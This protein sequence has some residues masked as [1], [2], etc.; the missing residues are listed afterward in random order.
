[1]RCTCARGWCGLLI[2]PNPEEYEKIAGVRPNAISV[3]A[4][5]CDRKQDVHFISRLSHDG[6]LE[7][8]GDLLRKT[9]CIAIFSHRP[10]Q[11]GD[12]QA[13]SVGC[14]SHACLL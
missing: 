13:G 5:I 10:A 14:M 2:E 6:V 3:N 1:M 4:A 8:A 7:S 9:Q 12:M 11:I